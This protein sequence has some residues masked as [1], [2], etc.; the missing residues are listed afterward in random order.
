MLKNHEVVAEL[1]DVQIEQTKILISYNDDN[2]IITISRH[3]ENPGIVRIII[4]TF[5]GIFRNIQQYSIMFS[6]TEK[7]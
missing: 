5:S 4:Y 3:I 2:A 1:L 6:Q 7:Y